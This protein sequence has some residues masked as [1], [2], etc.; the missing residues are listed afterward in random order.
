MSIEER[1]Y[2]TIWLQLINSSAKVCS[3]WSNKKT[4]FQK[5]ID[6]GFLAFMDSVEHYGLENTQLDRLDINKEFN[7]NNCQFNQ[8][9]VENAKYEALNLASQNIIRF[10]N[11]QQFSKHYNLRIKNIKDCI[12][13]QRR[14]TGNWIFRKCLGK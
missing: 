8:R 6:D 13:G 4:G 12:N 1:K 11:I 7:I 14:N 3:E 2:F 9:I 10:N 5:F